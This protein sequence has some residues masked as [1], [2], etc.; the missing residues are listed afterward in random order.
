[1]LLNLNTA[2]ITLNLSTLIYCS[3][4]AL[5]NVFCGLL[6]VLTMVCKS[7]IIIRFLTV[8]TTFIV[9]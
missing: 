4:E 9:K 7:H 6:F 3:S 2:V 1:M 5:K 8:K